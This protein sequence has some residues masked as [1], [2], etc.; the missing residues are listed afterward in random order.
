MPAQPNPT[1]E[2]TCAG[3]GTA[4]GVS[5]TTVHVTDTDSFPTDCPQDTHTAELMF[6][7]ISERLHHRGNKVSITAWCYI[8]RA[9]Y[10]TVIVTLALVLILDET[11][12]LSKGNDQEMSDSATQP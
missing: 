5:K 4:L 3:T 1:P 8:Y 7:L 9:I 10:N 11:K 6:Y 2:T 12:S